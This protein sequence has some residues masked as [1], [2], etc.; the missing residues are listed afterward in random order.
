MTLSVKVADIKAA[1]IKARYPSEIADKLLFTKMSVDRSI[2]SV[3]QE[4]YAIRVEHDWV[5]VKN[6]KQATAS[7]NLSTDAKESTYIMKEVI[8]PQK[9]YPFT[10]NRCIEFINRWIGKEEIPFVSPNRLEEKP[11]K[12]NNNHFQSFCKFY[13]LKENEAYTWQFALDPKHPRYSY[14]Q[15]CIDFIKEE[16]KKDPEQIIQRLRDKLKK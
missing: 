16:I 5:L 4:K 12:F 11:G 13:N 15:K 1:D 6:P 9:K 8:D 10:T 14:S 2:P 7:F 3:G